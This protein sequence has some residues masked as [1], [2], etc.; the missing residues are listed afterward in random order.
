M[1][2]VTQRSTTFQPTAVLA[3]YLGLVWLS[4]P[5]SAEEWNRFRGPN[6]SGLSDAST[7]P[8]EW[9]DED[10]NWVVE[11]PGKGNASPISWGRNVF[12]AS[13]DEKAQTRT[14]QCL[15]VADGAEVWRKDIPFEP[16]KQHKNNSFASSTP[17]ADADHVYVLW[18]SKVSSPLIAYDHSGRKVWEYDLGPYLHGQG[19]ATSP[20]V[21][22]DVVLVANDH[23]AGSYLLAVDR[24]TGKER[25]KV[26][27]DGKRACYG[28]PCI[29][30]PVDRP[31][32]VIFSH[33]YE[34]IIG[35]DPK[36]GHQNWHIDVFGRESQR[37]LGSPVIA[38]NLVVASSGGVTGERQ[39][40]VVK[41]QSSG[42]EVKVEEAW[43]FIRQAP[44]VPTP[45]VYGEWLFMWNDGG[46][47]TCVQ[48]D[49][50]TVVWQKRIGGNFF[51][52]PVCIN[53]NLYCV[54]LDGEV[55]VIA[56]SDEYR[57]LARNPLGHPT[58]AT[59]AVS[60]GALLIRT[61]SHLFSIGGK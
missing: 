55:V 37:A 48:R 19:G 56:A 29:N 27:R 3:V 26:A 11:L 53:G 61:E 35:V 20:I 7:V 38:G 51:S 18:H 15:N 31:A 22:D 52:S 5:S 14:L 36:S 8:T 17:T 50:G 30:S 60:N 57:L 59:P 49:S 44:H 41:P 28:T 43:R 4:C 6:G 34:G 58:R 10:Y 23:Q 9:S 42:D 13:A 2:Q 1:S 45:L 24:L 25:W 32:E 40:V 12:V 54:D 46:I 39:V 16:Y 21:Y 47:A 33:C